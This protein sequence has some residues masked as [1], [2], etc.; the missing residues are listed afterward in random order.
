MKFAQP[1]ASVFVPDREPEEAA[2]ARTTHMGIGAHLDDLEFMSWGAIAECFQKTDRWYTGITVTDGRGSPRANLYAH[3][4]D[5]Q[6]MAVRHKEQ[7]KAAAIGEYAA[8]IT[9]D[10]PSSAIK[11][12]GNREVLDDLKKILTAAKPKKVYTHN[13]ADKHDTHVAVAIATIQAIREL[14]ENQRPEALYGCEVWRSLDW[15]LDEDKVIFDVSSQDNLMMSIMGAYD[16]QISGGKRY[17]LATMG[18][19][20]ANATY[21]ASHATDQATLLEY[22]M[23]L[24][25]L[26]RNPKLDINEYITQFIQRLSKEVAARIGKFAK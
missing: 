15:M 13:L 8:A 14:P 21:Y 11:I 1:S 12:P 17:D 6:M 26:I 4:T 24:T 9:L 7:L 2:L 20:R 5:E 16:S 19:K 25:A 18:R 3:Y 23:D 10:F 22:A